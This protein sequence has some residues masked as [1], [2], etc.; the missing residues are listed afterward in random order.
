MI[1]L[2][3][4]DEQRLGIDPENVHRAGDRPS[5]VRAEK[6]KEVNEEAIRSRQA[7][8]FL[9]NPTRQKR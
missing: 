3:E 6:V 1:Q 2:K 7:E 5:S 4:Q 9:I 8:D